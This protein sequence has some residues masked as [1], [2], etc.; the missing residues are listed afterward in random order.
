MPTGRGPGTPPQGRILAE[1]ADDRHAQGRR[2]LEEGRVGIGPVGH[3]P[4]RQIEQVQP[5]LDPPQ[6]FDGQFQLGAER[7]PLLRVDARQVLLADV[8]PG[9]QRQGDDSPCRVGDE[10]GQDDEDVPVDVRRTGRAGSRVVMDA[11]PLDVRPVPLRP[12]VVQGKS[13]PRGPLEQRPDDLGQ[14]ASGNAVGPLASGRDGD[15]AGL[16]LAAE[17]GRP[18]PASDGPTAPGQDGPEE[19]QGEPR[20]GPTIERGG[21]PGEPLAWGGRRVRR[22]H[23]GRLRSRCPAV[24]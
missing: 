24:W 20:G 2:R 21:E 3:H 6:Q 4:D 11:G 22:C 9:Q 8:E 7:R 14:Q 5:G 10:Q 12:G 16:I 19:Q 17:P 18:D 1:P 13:Q 23:G 15:V